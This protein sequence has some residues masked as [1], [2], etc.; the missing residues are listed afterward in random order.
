MLLHAEFI[1]CLLP[2]CINTARHKVQST[3]RRGRVNSMKYQRAGGCQLIKLTVPAFTEMKSG[4]HL[5]ECFG[6]SRLH[7][8]AWPKNPS[9]QEVDLGHGWGGRTH[10]TKHQVS[11]VLLPPSNVII[12][13]SG[14]LSSWYLSLLVSI[15]IVYGCKGQYWNI[16]HC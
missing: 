6:I 4:I 10:M 16:F 12:C 1:L 3:E 14:I 13:R 5:S 15:L 2:I 11:S 9:L 8:S 7:S